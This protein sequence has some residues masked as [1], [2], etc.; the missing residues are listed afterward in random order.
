MFESG[1]FSK[2]LFFKHVKGVLSA[3][4]KLW[5]NK[6]QDQGYFSSKHYKR[7]GLGIKVDIP[8]IRW[9]QAWMLNALAAVYTTYKRGK[10]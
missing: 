4:A 1:N 5:V 6:S 3:A 2:E 7:F 8:Y 10:K 9:G